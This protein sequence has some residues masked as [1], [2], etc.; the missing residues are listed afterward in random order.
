VA[1]ADGPPFGGREGAGVL[2]LAHDRLRVGV[3]AVLLSAPAAV[4]GSV[5]FDDL[6]GRAF[7]W[8]IFCWRLRR[9]LLVRSRFMH[10]LFG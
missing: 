9:Y 7:R 1:L 2:G 8:R 10:V 5:H 6:R 3:G 4:D